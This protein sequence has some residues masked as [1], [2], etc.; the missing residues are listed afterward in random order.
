MGKRRNITNIFW[1]RLSGP[2]LVEADGDDRNLNK[3]NVT[4]KL[5]DGEGLFS[6]LP[7]HLKIYYFVCLKY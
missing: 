1:Y 4:P 6:F 3:K 7:K 2:K 5:G